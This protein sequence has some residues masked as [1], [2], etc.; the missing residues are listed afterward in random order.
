MYISK[1]VGLRMHERHKML[2]QCWGDG[3]KIFDLLFVHMCKFLSALFDFVSLILHYRKKAR[4]DFLPYY[5]FSFLFLI[6]R[7]DSSMS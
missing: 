7:V 2:E 6:L 1:C 5:D 3:T 4:V